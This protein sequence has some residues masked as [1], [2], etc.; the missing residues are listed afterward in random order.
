MYLLHARQL[1][2]KL[3]PRHGLRLL[4]LERLEKMNRWAVNLAFPFLTAGVLV[5]A[6][7]LLQDRDAVRNWLDPK[8]LG[9]VVLWLLFL[10]LLYLRYGVHVQGRRLALLTIVAFALMLVTF[11]APAHHFAQGGRP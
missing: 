7:L 4:S 3:P 6:A 1:R 11:A 8:V 10:V 5:G 2:A 9:S